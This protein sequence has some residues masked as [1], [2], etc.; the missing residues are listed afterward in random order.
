LTLRGGLSP[1]LAGGA[2]ERRPMLALSWL[3]VETPESS[4]PPES[5]VARGTDAPGDRARSVLHRF[6]C[7]LER[8][9]LPDRGDWVSR[10]APALTARIR[11]DAVWVDRFSAFEA[12]SRRTGITRGEATRTLLDLLGGADEYFAMPAYD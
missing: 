11:P 12:A 5:V 7:I 8:L 1:E 2:A 3:S 9:K 6:D 4:V 10:C